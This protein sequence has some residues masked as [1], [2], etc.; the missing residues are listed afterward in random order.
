[1]TNSLDITGL[2]GLQIDLQQLD[3]INRVTSSNGV[4]TVS[5]SGNENIGTFALF[6]NQSQP[7]TLAVA[8][9]PVAQRPSH[10]QSFDLRFSGQQKGNTSFSYP[11][12]QNTKVLGWNADS[13][14]IE[15]NDGNP[16][17]TFQVISANDSADGTP[18]DLIFTTTG[19]APTIDG[20]TPTIVT[21]FARGTRLATAQG[22]TAVEHL[23]VGDLVRTVSGALQ[24][25][26][27]VGVRAVR[28]AGHTQ[29]AR[30]MPVQIVADAF[31]PGLPSCDLFLSPEHAVFVDGVMVPVHALVN[32]ATVRQ[33]AVEQISYYH[34]ELPQHDVVLAEGLAAESYLDTGNRHTLASYDRVA[35][36][37]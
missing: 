33:I 32:G 36:A 3:L 2:N 4:F 19:P 1:M 34:V 6:A 11:Q 25:I 28:C 30:V 7:M 21:C 23:Q 26:V 14:L 22:A 20:F 18:D 29:P 16:V 9:V 13:I 8:T 10:S 17:F 31:G 37:A 15:T 27:W 5:S 12:S 35:R 24:P